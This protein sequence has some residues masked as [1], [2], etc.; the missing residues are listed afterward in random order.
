MILLLY[1]KQPLAETLKDVE[2]FWSPS[3]LFKSEDKEMQEIQTRLKLY[4]RAICTF[5]CIALLQIVG[6]V[7]VPI[8]ASGRNLPYAFWL[9]NDAASPYYEIVF[10][11]EVYALYI[12]LSTVIGADSLFI[13][14]CGSLAVQLK[15]L[16][17]RLRNMKGD[18]L[19]G[20]KECFIQH[21]YLLK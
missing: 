10:I 21:R 19:V 15:L 13:A 20:F 11:L 1:Y 7:F 12:L 6:F 4:K 17:H 8:L 18:D 14:F 5:V 16:A 2:S 3:M 9:P